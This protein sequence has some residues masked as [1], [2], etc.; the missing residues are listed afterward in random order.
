MFARIFLKI[1]CIHLSNLLEFY[2]SKREH[3][4]EWKR[5]RKFGIDWVGKNRVAADLPLAMERKTR[6]ILPTLHLCSELPLPQTKQRQTF[7]WPPLTHHPPFPLLRLASSTPTASHLPRSPLDFSLIWLLPRPVP[8]QLPQRL[9]AHDPALLLA[10]NSQRG[11][12]EPI[13]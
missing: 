7:S 11:I 1:Q 3:L 5:S 13:Y 2:P 12:I 10:P 9:S 4:R 6:E 8:Q